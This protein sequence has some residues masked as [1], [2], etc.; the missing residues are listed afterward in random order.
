MKR[1]NA[2]KGMSVW[3]HD[4][5]YHALKDVAEAK[6]AKMSSLASEAVER[7]LVDEVWRSRK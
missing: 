3:L 6:G 1:A 2:K 5:Q 4:K 7:Y